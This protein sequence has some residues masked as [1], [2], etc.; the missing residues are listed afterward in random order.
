MVGF[1][2]ILHMWGNLFK[3]LPGMVQEKKGDLV[4]G[5]W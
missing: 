5:G 2:S 4:V 3:S 1:L